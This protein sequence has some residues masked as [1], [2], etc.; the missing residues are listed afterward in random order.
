MALAGWPT[1]VD[2]TGGGQDGT[3]LDAAL[4]AAMEAAIEAQTGSVT[5]PTVTPADTTDEVV[6]ARGSLPTLDGRLDVSLNNDGTLKTQANLITSAQAQTLLGAK[7]LIPND[8]LLLWS[9]GDAAAPD[10]TVVSGAGAAVARVGVGL[11]DTQQMGYGDFAAKLTFGSAAARLTWTLLNAT[12]FTRALALRGRKVSFGALVKTSIANHASI[13]VDD[14]ISTT[15][16]DFHTGGGTVE[17]LTV[18]HTISASATKLNVYFKVSAAGSAYVGA[19]TGV[20]ADLAPAAW[21]PCAMIRDVFRYSI[22]G[23]VT[24]GVN[25][26][27]ARPGG[28]AIITDVQLRVE[29]APVGA[30]M[31]IDVN[32]YDGAAATSMFTTKPTIL[33]GGFHGGA[34]P[35]GTYARR[36]LHGSFGAGAPVGGDILTYDV[37]QVGSATAGSDLIVEIRFRQYVRELSQLLQFDSV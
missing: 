25:K 17:W 15:A 11:A 9:Q 26:G 36:C 32:T 28:P 5:N 29:T 14:G 4:F 37:D 23:G 3:V 24:T 34:A 19:M 27:V 13:V 6:Q 16:S 2:D 7:N 10:Y 8:L 35:D 21:I 30:N 20:L 33:A 18:T 12:E 22:A 31:I 1:I